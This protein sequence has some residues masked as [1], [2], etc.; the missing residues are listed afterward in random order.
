MEQPIYIIN[1]ILIFL[2][3][4]TPYYFGIYIRYKIFPSKSAPPLKHQFLLG[5]PICLVVITPMIPVIIKTITD[6][7]ILVTIGIIIEQGMIL[8]ETATS[9]IKKLTKSKV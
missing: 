1:N 3:T 2:L 8:N 6:W 9:R 5:I 7:S 4:I